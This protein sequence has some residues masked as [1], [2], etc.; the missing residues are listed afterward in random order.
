MAFLKKFGRNLYGFE[1]K[2][3]LCSDLGSKILRCRGG[4]V[5]PANK[6]FSWE[7]SKLLVTNI[8]Y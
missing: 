1:K 8:I 5:V 4:I 2:Q 7:L 3:Y 6:Y